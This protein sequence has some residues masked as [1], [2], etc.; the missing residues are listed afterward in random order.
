MKKIDKK[1]ISPI[2]IKLNEFN[3][4]NQPSKAQLDEREKYDNI[5]KLRDIVQLKSDVATTIIEQLD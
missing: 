1:Y 4:N 5:H 2:D 3:A